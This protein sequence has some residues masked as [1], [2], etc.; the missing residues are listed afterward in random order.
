[1]AI[2]T[3]IYSSAGASGGHSSKSGAQQRHTIDKAAVVMQKVDELELPWRQAVV[4]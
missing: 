4:G 3:S 2:D 1:M